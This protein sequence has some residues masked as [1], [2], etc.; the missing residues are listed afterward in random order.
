V[1]DFLGEINDTPGILIIVHGECW[2]KNVPV[3]QSSLLCLIAQKLQKLTTQ[4]FRRE[5]Q[6][7]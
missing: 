3:G 4:P 6:E 1:I 2:M 5:E 7:S